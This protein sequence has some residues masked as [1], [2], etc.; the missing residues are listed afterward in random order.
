MPPT[1]SRWPLAEYDSE[2]VTDW[3]GG[4][5]SGWRRGGGQVEAHLSSPQHTTACFGLEVD[6]LMSLHRY[7]IPRLGRVWEVEEGW[8]GD[9][10]GGGVEPQQLRPAAAGRLKCAA[11]A[12]ALLSSLIGSLMSLKVPIVDTT[13]GDRLT[14]KQLRPHLLPHWPLP[15]P[16]LRCS[17]CP[18]ADGGKTAAPCSVDSG[19]EGATLGGGG[20]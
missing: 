12:V 4:E 6:E 15:P 7:N 18:W 13:C 8:E 14:S 1:G 20:A 16:S 17:E 10:G 3:R 5:G 19:K 11:A 2:R 9:G